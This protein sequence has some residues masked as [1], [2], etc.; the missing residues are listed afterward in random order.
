MNI[1][2][3]LKAFKNDQSVIVID[4]TFEPKAI[5]E[6]RLDTGESIFWVLDGN[7]LWLEID[8]NSEEVKL[9]E[10]IDEEFDGS[11]DTV[12]YAGED[13]EFSYEGSATVLDED[14][15]SLDSVSFRDFQKV[16]GE[17]LRLVEF[18]A[19]GDTLASLGR[20]VTEEDLQAV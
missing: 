8:P 7:E 3:A 5:D 14:G 4:K 19:S 16:G 13:Y 6:L 17:V 15:D 18:E 1:H 12:F 11:Q 20:I 10:G 9:F 2:K